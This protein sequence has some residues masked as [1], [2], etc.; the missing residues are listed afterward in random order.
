MLRKRGTRSWGKEVGVLSSQQAK[1]ASAAP[2]RE[3]Q[4]ATI[5]EAVWQMWE[6]TDRAGDGFAT[7]PTGIETQWVGR[8]TE[9]S[10]HLQIL[11]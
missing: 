11:K 2:R 10:G 9:R 1:P 5:R 8:A 3:S 4:T 7:D 6:R